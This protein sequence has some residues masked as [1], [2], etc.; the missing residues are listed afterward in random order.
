MTRILI[1]I[2]IL[3]SVSTQA[4]DRDYQAPDSQTVTVVN[5]HSDL[6]KGIAIGVALTCT[7]R[8]VY[9]KIKEKRW[10]WCGEDRK[11]EP[12]PDPG[13]AVIT[14]NNLSDNP[15]GVRLTQ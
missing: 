1:L 3:F 15:I 5:K 4:S 11:P 7:V 6:G 13:P 9:T 2:A 10:T 14:P 12:L 8:L